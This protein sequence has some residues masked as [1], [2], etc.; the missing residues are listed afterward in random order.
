VYI[1]YF[2]KFH[3]HPIDKLLSLDRKA[4]EDM[5]IEYIKSMRD[6]GLSYSSIYG[7]IAAIFS[8]LDLNDISINQKKVKK[9]YGEHNKTIKDEAYTREDLQRMFEQASFR[10]KLIIAIYSSTGIRKGAII[11]LKLKHLKKIPD[12][13]LYK[14][15]IYENTKEEYYTY[16]TPECASIIDKYIE[17]RKKNGEKIN[18]NSLLLRNDFDYRINARTPKS[19]SD[20]SLSRV[21]SDFQIRIGMREV[22]HSTENYKY[23]RSSTSLYHGFRKYFNTCLANCDVNVTIKE[24]LMGHSI[25]LDNAY[26]RPKEEKVLC[27]YVKAI[28]DLT[29][30]EENRLKRRV[31]KLEVEKSLMDQ[32]RAEVF[33]IKQEMAKYKQN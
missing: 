6:N 27:E 2:E 25:G 1:K 28:N 26:F 10:V 19:A 12:Y 24:M 5:L 7:R 4:I 11:D 22:N 8:F 14:F 3:Q 9:F 13:N 20:N 30:N 18:E 17:H 21:M 15:T 31:E 33:S 29:I 23:H 32:L 16:C